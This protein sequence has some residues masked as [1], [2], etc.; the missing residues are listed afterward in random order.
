MKLRAVGQDV[1][2]EIKGI[3]S[4]SYIP[5]NGW[6]TEPHLFPNVTN[7]GLANDAES[8]RKLAL[9]SVWK[10]YQINATGANELLITRILKVPLEIGDINYLWQIVPIEHRLATTYT[11]E[12][13][14]AKPESPRVW[15]T[16]WKYNAGPPENTE[17]SDCPVDFSIWN[18]KG[19]VQFD[20]QVLRWDDDN[21]IWV[22]ADLWLYCAFKVRGV[23]NFKRHRY[24]YTVPTGGKKNGA[25]M[26]IIKDPTLILKLINKGG[27]GDADLGQFIETRAHVVNLISRTNL[28][29]LKAIIGQ[30]RLLVT[31][32]SG[33]MHLAAGL[34]IP[35]VAIF[36]AT[37]KE[38]G[39]F[40]YGDGHEVVE[41]ELAC[42]PCG[43]HGAKSCPESHF[44][45]MRLITVEEVFAACQRVLRLAHNLA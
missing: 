34:G 9:A 15:G 14:E 43:L 41:A 39:F 45:C 35:V 30:M 22:E 5:A 29:D 23:K 37:T 28:S 42:R 11:N 6:G 7:S 40:P 3:E 27:P 24:I 21:E 36:G 13:G 1:G 33:P 4:L 32:D 25:G 16:F 10:W 2:G 44:L 19:I 38:L 20:R 17:E 26:E 18:E 12:A 31:N 8:N